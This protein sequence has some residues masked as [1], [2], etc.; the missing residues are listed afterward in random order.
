MS[1]MRSVFAAGGAA[2]PLRFALR[3][4]RGGLRGFYVSLPASRSA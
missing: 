1:A 3:E 2:T 4:M